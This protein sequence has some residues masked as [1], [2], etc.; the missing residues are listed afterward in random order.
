MYYYYF[1]IV[2]DLNTSVTTD[3]RVIFGPDYMQNI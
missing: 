2:N 1:E 3:N